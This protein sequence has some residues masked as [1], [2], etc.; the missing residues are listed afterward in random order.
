MSIVASQCHNPTASL[1]KDETG[2]RILGV[3]VFCV[4][5]LFNMMPTNKASAVCHQYFSYVLDGLY[6]EIGKASEV[7]PV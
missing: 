6:K 3:I 7:Y 2:Y 1:L 4:C 5:S